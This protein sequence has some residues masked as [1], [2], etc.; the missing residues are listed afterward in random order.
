MNV[1][2][3]AGV[4]MYLY[5][6]KFIVILIGITHYNCFIEY[7]NILVYVCMYA[8]RDRSSASAMRNTS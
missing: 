8:C 1:S 2:V 3:S 7:L 4:G 5:I 6:D